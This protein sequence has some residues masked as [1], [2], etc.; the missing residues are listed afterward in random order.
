M[1]DNYIWV[2]AA[3]LALALYAITN[4]IDKILREKYVKSNIGLS[5]IFIIKNFWFVFLLPFVKIKA[6]P[7]FDVLLLALLGLLWI[8]VVYPFIASLSI[9]EV[10]R[11]VPV[12][13][14][15]PLFAL[16][17]SYIFLNEVLPKTYYLSFILLF[18]GGILVSTHFEDI[19]KIRI[20]KSFYL[21]LLSS[22]SFSFYIV[23]L[24]YLLLKYDFW[25]IFVLAGISASI[26]AAIPLIFEKPR[27]EVW[28]GIKSLKGNAIVLF[29]TTSIVGYS[30][31]LFYNYAFLLG[32]VAIVAA[33]DGFQSLFLFFYIIVLS[34]FFPKFFKEE[35]S[36]SA[37]ITKFVAILIMILGLI[38]LYI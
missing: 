32:P 13:N 34:L 16:F 38:L 12:W 33:L 35:T 1:A 27:K 30:A 29:I 17:L 11:V 21:M 7:P 20:S 9:E 37:I 4:V 23:T 31:T 8:C 14:T 15:Y 2:F 22:I 18:S 28:A 6:M 24:K 5:L 19:K 26:L 10:S 3:I 25:T 36:K